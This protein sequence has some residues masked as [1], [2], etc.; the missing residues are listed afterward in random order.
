MHHHHH[1]HSSIHHTHHHHHFNSHHH[2]SSNNEPLDYEARVKA[3]RVSLILHV[4]VIVFAFIFAL[5]AIIMV[6]RGSFSPFMLIPF[7]P[8]PLVMIVFSLIG[9]VRAAK[10]LNS[11]P[12]VPE[13]AT[14]ENETKSEETPATTSFDA[15]PT[16]SSALAQNCVC[17][18]CGFIYNRE[19]EKCPQCGEATKEN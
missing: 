9:I 18:K 13:E 1:T 2:I 3:T 17:P 10:F 8:I 12:P 19:N 4:F 5:T 16:T 15:S 7:I 11:E 14:K 6:E